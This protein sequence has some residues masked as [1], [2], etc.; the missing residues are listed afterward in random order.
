MSKSA[1]AG[2]E[3]VA[4]PA[5]QRLRRKLIDAR[6][7]FRE[8][9]TSFSK[10]FDLHRGFEAFSVHILAGNIEPVLNDMG[11]MTECQVLKWEKQGNVT[12]VECRLDFVDAE[13]EEV[14]SVRTV[15][16]GV[17]GSDKGI[18]K[19]ISNAR[20]QGHI[21]A[22][23]LAIGIDVEDDDQRAISVGGMSGQAS[24]PGPAS[25]FPAPTSRP[26]EIETMKGEIV[27]VV[28]ADLIARFIGL[29]NELG[30]K[31]DVSAF[32][33][34]NGALANRLER[35]GHLGLLGTLNNALKVNLAKF[36]AA[37]AAAA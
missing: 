20:K 36:E 31:E 30:S 13:T 15:G 16:E 37:N 24:H 34:R 10:H 17:D 21:Q 32:A 7:K 9:Q 11:V 8:E 4:A 26:Y 35:E 18:G 6:R 29:L 33:G 23:N 27:E 28:E 19:A 14:F 25:S 22:F 12:V 5:A 1:D 3:P 2:T